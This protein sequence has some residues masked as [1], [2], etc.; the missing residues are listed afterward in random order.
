MKTS[1]KSFSLMAVLTLVLMA[2]TSTAALAADPA[3]EGWLDGPW[4]YSGV[5]YG[6]LPQAPMDLFLDQ[7]EI[8][9]VPESLSNILKALEMAAMLEFEAH[10]GRLGFFVSPIYYKAKYNENFEGKLG[11]SHELTFKET[12]WL[13]DYGVGLDIGT[14]KGVTVTPY[15]GARYLHDDLSIE[16]PPGELDH[17]VNYATTIKFNTPIAGVKAAMNIGEDW[18]VAVEGDW[19]VWNDSLVNKTYQYTGVGS[20]HFTMKKLPARVL[21]GYRY[22]HLD[23]ENDVT[24]VRLKVAIKGPFIGLGI[25]F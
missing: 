22:L 24:T 14:W 18:S 6:W 10:K 4:R 11:Q 9:N 25:S 17:G 8:G 16:V 2:A 3:E 12:V 7:D 19:G 20:Y 1:L 21:F 23:I 5:I 13:V 15:F